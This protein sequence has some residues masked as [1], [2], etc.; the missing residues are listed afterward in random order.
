MGT[1]NQEAAAQIASFG[2]L[3]ILTVTQDVSGRITGAFPEFD[4][5]SVAE[6][7]LCVVTAVTA[8]SVA[9][10]ERSADLEVAIRTLRSVPYSY[11][12]YLFGQMV[13]SDEAEIAEGYSE[14]IGKRIDRKMN[15]YNTHLSKGLHPTPTKGLQNIMLLWMGRISPPGREDSAADRLDQLEILPFLLR[16]YTLMASFATHCL[17]SRA[18]QGV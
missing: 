15:F 10:V 3:G 9:S 18:D 2:S 8:A 14:S 12:D 16:H 17:G 4:Q 5:E 11:R 7:T 13:L 1:Q 6:E